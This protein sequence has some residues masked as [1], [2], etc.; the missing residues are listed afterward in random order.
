MLR[1]VGG[2]QCSA[3]EIIYNEIATMTKYTPILL[4]LFVLAFATVGTATAG[5]SC[6]GKS[7][8]DK[9]ERGDTAAVVMPAQSLA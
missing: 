8:G 4:T 3:P 5:S 2:V 1:I 9:G 6:G 7:K